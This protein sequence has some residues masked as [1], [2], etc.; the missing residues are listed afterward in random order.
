MAA[1]SGIKARR[2]AR[3]AEIEPPIYSSM[4]SKAMRSKAKKLDLS[5][6]S[7]DL[8]DALIHARLYDDSGLIDG[9]ACGPASPEDLAA[10]A[11]ACGATPEM[12]A[13][14]ASGSGGLGSP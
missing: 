6:A 9:S 11:A 12:L 2:S 8:S 10:V 4:T 7:K 3:L 13:N 14:L 5:A 1:D